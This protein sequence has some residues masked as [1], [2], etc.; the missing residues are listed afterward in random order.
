MG[1]MNEKKA[2]LHLGFVH[3]GWKVGND[4]FFDGLSG[5][6]FGGIC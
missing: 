3:I 6:R 1:V 5:S 4:D 2:N